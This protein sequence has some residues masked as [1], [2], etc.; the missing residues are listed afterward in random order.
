MR[1]LPLTIAVGVV[2]SVVP[3]AAAA[4][5]PEDEG[6]LRPF[7]GH[8]HISDPGHLPPVRR[9]V[10]L[11]GK[12]D[13]FGDEEQPGRIADVGAFGNYAYLG[14]FAQPN[15]EDGGVY[16]VDISDPKAPE[17]V[18]FIPASPGTFVGEGVQ[19]LDM[20]TASFD[21][22]VLIHNNETCLPGGGALFEDPRLGLGGPGGASLWDVSNPRRPRVLAEHVGDMDPSEFGLPHNSH[23]AFGWQQG[24]RAYMVVV[25]N[26]EFGDTDID[27]FEIT[28]PSSPRLVSETG[29]ADFPEIAEDPPAN[30]AQYLNHDMIVKQVGSRWLMLSSYW[31][32]GYVILDVTD[33]ANPVFLRDTDFGAEPFAGELGLPADWIPEGNAHQAEFSRDNRYFLGADE[34]FNPFRVMGEILGGRHAGD[35]YSATLGSDVPDVPEEG[36]EGGTDFVGPACTPLPPAQAPIALIE[37][38]TCTFTIK[39]QVVQAAGYE[40]GLVFND[41]VT[42][43][44]NCD[45]QVFMLAVADIPFLF[46][47][48]DTGLKLLDQQFTDSCQHAT[49]APFSASVD[50]NMGPVF[51]GW[52]YL[53]LYDAQTMQA[54]GHWALPEALDPR[55]AHGFGDLSIHEVA[56]DPTEN[57][58]YISHYSG[59]FRVVKFGRGGI[60][61]VGAFIDAGGNNFWG[62]EVLSTAGGTARER[63]LVLA[64]DRDAGLYIFRYT[65]P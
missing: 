18:G 29:M 16:V 50:T 39:A 62:V 56:T 46:V 22:Q 26:G 30:G 3:G 40:M 27:I 65:G 17:Q 43:A 34:D 1:K 21:G 19:V 6:V 24:D 10:E 8:Q 36:I 57:L 54:V 7:D 2:L 12:L 15:C 48:R 4:S 61:E 13:L 38:G 32:G 58:A 49:P 47:G 42:D 44:P 14:A 53:H 64:S 37:R 28:D 25:D 63:P 60:R 9:N 55:F 45:A 51:D 20:K 33:P 59:G 41:Q 5:P 11:V 31:D 52:G 35:V 23:S